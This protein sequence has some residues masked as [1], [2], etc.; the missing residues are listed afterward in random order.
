MRHLILILVLLVAGPAA[1]QNVCEVNCQVRV[2]QSF[3]A[4]TESDANATGYVLYINN[5]V[6]SDFPWLVVNGFVEFDVRSGLSLGSYSFMIGVLRGGAPEV[7]TD[8][9]TLTVVRRRVRWR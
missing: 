6:R 4:F 1:A 3:I 2:G 7:R 8:P 9:N 5:V